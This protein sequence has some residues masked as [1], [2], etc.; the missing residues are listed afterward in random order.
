M[1]LLAVLNSGIT[2]K[3]DMESGIS[4]SGRQVGP[5]DILQKMTDNLERIEEQQ[6]RARW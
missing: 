2:L 3:R 6:P 4:D 5:E 1:K